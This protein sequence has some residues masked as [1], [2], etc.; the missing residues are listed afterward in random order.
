MN[1]TDGS[2]IGEN[3]RASSTAKSERYDACE[4]GAINVLQKIK[5]PADSEM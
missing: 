4:T 2:T 1:K 5:L 3:L